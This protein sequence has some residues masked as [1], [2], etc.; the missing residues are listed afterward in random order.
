MCDKACVGGS[1]EVDR[2]EAFGFGFVVLDT[3]GYDL[4]GVGGA[5]T[6]YLG[7]GCAEGFQS[8]V[9]DQVKVKGAPAGW[10]DSHSIRI[11]QRMW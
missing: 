5:G 3:E 4:A 11:P 6:G 7:P 2:A 8:G 9:D 1:G 10:V